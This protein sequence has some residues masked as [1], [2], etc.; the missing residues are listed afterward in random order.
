MDVTP[1]TSG[2]RAKSWLADC[3]AWRGSTA[4][5]PA[6]S[7]KGANVV[8]NR[9]VGGSR[10]AISDSSGRFLRQSPMSAI[11]KLISLL[12]DCCCCWSDG[13]PQSIWRATSALS[14]PAWWFNAQGLKAEPDMS[15]ARWNKPEKEL[16][17]NVKINFHLFYSGNSF[18][19]LKTKSSRLKISIRPPGSAPRERDKRIDGY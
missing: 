15:T 17:K 2:M 5:I 12:L 9:G 10:T 8:Q 13:G 14:H 4:K 11:I 19:N 1:A 16:G 3:M 7:T 6:P 18:R